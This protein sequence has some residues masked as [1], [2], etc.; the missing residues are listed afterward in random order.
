MIFGY[1]DP[2]RCELGTVLF[3]SR[4]YRAYIAYA[5]E[6]LNDRSEDSQKDKNALSKRTTGQRRD[7]RERESEGERPDA[8]I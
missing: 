6:S 1:A 4:L 8:K 3:R 2:A 7:A 5:G